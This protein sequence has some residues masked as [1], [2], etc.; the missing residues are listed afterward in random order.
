VRSQLIFAT[1]MLLVYCRLVLYRF[2]F[3]GVDVSSLVQTFDLMRVEL[4]Q[5]VPAAIPLGA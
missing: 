4:R 3:C 5:L 2:G 1:S